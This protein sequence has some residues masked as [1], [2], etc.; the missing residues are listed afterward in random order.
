VQLSE[1]QI[2]IADHPEFDDLIQFAKGT[3]N[4]GIFFVGLVAVIT[5]HNPEFGNGLGINV[6]CEK[7]ESSRGS[8]EL[9]LKLSGWFTYHPQPLSVLFHSDFMIGT[10]PLFDHRGSVSAC[11][12]KLLAIDFEKE[13]Q[14][15]FVDV[16]GDIDNI[17][18]V[19]FLGSTGNFHN[20]FSFF[21]VDSTGY[22]STNS[23]CTSSFEGEAFLLAA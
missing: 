23:Y 3:Y 20:G 10:Q 17:I 21:V 13:A 15:V 14:S 5:L 11:V 8:H 4:P 12:G 1:H 16:H 2:I 7:T 19:D 18:E 6:V 9:V 22:E